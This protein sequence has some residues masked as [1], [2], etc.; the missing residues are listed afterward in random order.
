M[1]TS[2]NIATIIT[3]I[4]L[5]TV[6]LMQVR[7]AGA[8]LFGSAESTFRTRRGVEATLFRFTILLGVLFVLLS[9]TSLLLS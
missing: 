7:G 4:V 9:I 5:V 1:D 2:L 8:A 6:I 3:A